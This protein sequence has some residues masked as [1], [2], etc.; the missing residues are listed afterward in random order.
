VL[1]RSVDRDVAQQSLKIADFG[2]LFV[3]LL[4]VTMVSF[5]APSPDTQSAAIFVALFFTILCIVFIRALGAYAPHRWHEFSFA[6]GWPLFAAILT[7]LAGQIVSAS[8][9]WALKPSWVLSWCVL[10]AGYFLISRATCF[11][12]AHNV[13]KHRGFHQRVAIVGGGQA[14]EDALNL[15]S[16][17]RTQHIEIVGLF[18]DRSDARSPESIREFQKVGKIAD[19]NDYARR[20][21]VDLIVVAIPMSAEKRL[22][23]IL[24]QLWE[25]PVDIRISAASSELKLSPKAYSYLGDLPLLNVFERPL[26]GWDAVL[27]D[28]V[29]KVL[30]LVA[31]VVFS[32]LMLVVA[33]AIRYDSKGPILFKQM[34]H[35]FNNELIGVYKF[36]SMYTD[37]SDATASKLVTKDDPRVTQVGRFIRRTSIDELPQLFNV[38]KGE[39]S[40]VG[41]RPHATHA[42]AAG[43]LYDEVVDGYFARHKVKPGITG[44]AQINGWRGE[45]DTKDKLEQ[46]V[47]HDLE[48]IDRWSLALDLYILAKTPFS[49][50]KNENAY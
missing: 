50:I 44:W 14:A 43:T 4:G 24:K 42:K 48:Y 5:V 49:L 40:M 15:L 35:G 11:V 26:R 13:R 16:K 41:P 18:D 23:K 39:L 28:A 21:D 22:L 6:F 3:L 29:D 34:R 19:L 37:M 2:A 17:S 31:L 46:R 12:W 10:S 8:T 45:T 20:Q 33:V 47:K 38:L 32:P 36:R 7:G 30:A 1:G 9:Y 27:K 25:L